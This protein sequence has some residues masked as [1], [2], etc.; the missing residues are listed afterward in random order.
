MEEK[1]TA[2]A[3]RILFFNTL[4][5]TICFSAWMLNGTLVSFLVD[6]H[7]FDWTPVQIGWLL[8]M[9]VLTG[10]I[11]RLPF[12]LL[13]DR[14][15][16]RYIYSI[17]M[18]ISA[19][20][21][22]LLSFTNSYVLFLLYSFGFGLTGASF[23]VGVAYTSVWFPAKWQ[24]TALG[25]FGIGNLGAAL[26]TLIGPSILQFLTDNG[27][28]IERWRWL[29]IIY[30]GILFLMAVIFFVFT[31]NKKPE[32]NNK[33]FI[34]LLEP[35]RNIRVWRFG[36]YYFLVFGCF[37]AFSQW[38]VP[39]Y[40]NVYYMPFVKAGI[41]ASLFSFPASVIRMLGGW[42]SDK[43]G[44]RRVLFSVFVASTILGLLLIFPRMELYSPGKG[45][46]SK[47]NGI[48]TSITSN[49]I[50]VNDKEYQLTPLKVKPNLNEDGFLV[51]PE[52]IMWQEPTVQLGD[53]VKKNQL[54]AKGITKI[55]FQA[56]VNIFVFF[57]LLI[58]LAW[59]LGM[60]AVYK[61]IPMYFPNTVGVVGGTVGVLGG[62]G[63][64]VGPIIFG[65]LLELT[66]LWT[67]SWL[68]IFFLSLTCLIW[69]QITINKINSG[70]I[71]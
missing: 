38:L 47:N 50:K 20:P 10:S 66:G 46:I 18:L 3:R 48:V 70:K 15:G 7:V 30:A 61:F 21:M 51:L 14:Y 16:G 44:P 34:E 28:N 59:G 4:A 53:T 26:T 23:A 13:T 31:E 64:F 39:Y 2:K 25:I 40:L 54:I 69:M 62:L 32:R 41:V 24:G 8:G 11:F 33:K 9:P 45:I 29:P 56:N 19:I 52:K 5:F 36:L 65:Y 55:N 57:V 22:F 63:G 17:L 35:L 68:F 42:L 12:G 1:V 27:Q 49:S 37:V 43:Y 58:G 6:N 71:R 67:S 60:G